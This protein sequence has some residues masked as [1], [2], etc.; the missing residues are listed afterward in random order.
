MKI[1][2]RR[3]LAL[4]L[5]AVCLADLVLPVLATETGETTEAT[6]VLREPGQCGEN[7]Y[8][9]Y[10]G[11][12]LTLTG[13][14][15]MDDFPDGA[16]WADERLLMKAVVIGDGI[17][18]IGAH[19]FENYDQ[20][21][22]VRLGKDVYEI[23]TAAFRSCDALKE[24]TFPKSFRIFGEDSFR[25]CA[26]MYKM[27]FEGG[28]PK[29]KLNCLWDTTAKLIFPAG[30]P[31]PKEHIIQLEESF[32]TRIEF[33]CSDGTDPYVTEQDLHEATAPT[34]ET[35]PVTVATTE[36]TQP[37]T[38]PETTAATVATVE[39]TVQTT[40]PATT[41]AAGTSPTATASEAAP[42][43]A[44]TAPETSPQEEAGSDSGIGFAII[45]ACLSLI[46]IGALI[47]G[48]RRPSG[49][50]GR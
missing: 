29:F 47:F 27:H 44:Q 1:N 22:D 26:L 8:W 16:P 34:V 15:A 49:K 37:Q 3:I 31:W 9:T 39:T 35:E 36:A 20:L 42:T 21:T 40:A 6:T 24:I 10:A 11:G 17:T 43:A 13:T 23:G 41:E 7:V 25:S 30:N 14:G 2:I 48:R 33:L 38:E 50:Y 5:A 28:M 18:Y 19:A 12:T 46:A 4:L 32:Q 45:M